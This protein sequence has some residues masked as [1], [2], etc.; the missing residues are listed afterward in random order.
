[1]FNADGVCCLRHQ[2]VHRGD[3][4]ADALSG[5]AEVA[6]VIDALDLVEGTYKLDVAVHKRDG[7]PY[8]YHR[9]LYTFRVKSR[10]EGRRHL[11]AAAPLGRSRP[12]S[13]SSAEDSRLLTMLD[14]AARRSIVAGRSAAPGD[15]SSSPTACSTCCIPATCAT[16]RPR[17]P[18]GDVLIVGVNSD[19]SVR[20]NKGPTRPI[21]PERERAEILAALACVDAVVIFDEETPARDHRSAPAGRARQ[22]R[23]LGRRRHRRPRHR[24]GPRR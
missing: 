18:L 11:P 17:A 10:T 13:S 19:R 16:C 4:V 20:A 2:H 12:T 9:L 24:R 15:A 22:G 21:T 1:M 8:D 6:F 5:E 7:Y 14:A 23:R 3:R